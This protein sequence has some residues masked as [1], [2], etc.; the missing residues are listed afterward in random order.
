M[1]ACSVNTIKSIIAGFDE[2][3]IAY[4]NSLGRKSEVI[5]GGVSKFT[6]NLPY[7]EHFIFFESADGK[8]ELS[9][10]CVDCTFTFSEL[11]D[12]FGE[13]EIHYN[14][15][16]NYSKFISNFSTAGVAELYFVKDNRFEFSDSGQFIESNPYGKR[17]NYPTLEF[18]EFC[19][20][21]NLT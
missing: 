7:I 21:L 4:F 20:M 3:G 18:N 12:E 10:K 14:F 13:F 17:I 9:F 16:D 15:R 8:N 11:E 1:N 19:L 6:S 2:S 5:S